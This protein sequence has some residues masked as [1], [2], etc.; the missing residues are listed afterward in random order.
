MNKVLKTVIYIAIA[1][2]IV[3]L[4]LYPKLKSEEHGP[5]IT[6]QQGS[7]VLPVE[8]KIIKP[9]RIE[10]IIKITGAILANES[11]ALKSEISGKVERIYFQEGQRIK[12]GDLLLSINDDEI[13]AQLERLKYTQ[14]L[15]EDIE[16]RQRQ[17]LEK[18][19]ISREEYEI[20][21]TTLNTTQSDIKETEARL[22]KH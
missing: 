4:I 22:E 7:T 3:G 2:I 11:V 9:Q 18:E 21:L 20:A 14:K 8:A 19:A 15:N 6:P 16:Y 1:I 10:N 12:K 5:E 17:L 13:V